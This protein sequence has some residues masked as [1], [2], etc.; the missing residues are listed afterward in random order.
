MGGSE[1]TLHGDFTSASLLLRSWTLFGVI[2]LTSGVIRESLQEEEGTL[3]DAASAQVYTYNTQ[4]ENACSLCTDQPARHALEDGGGG[5]SC[6]CKLYKYVSDQ[7]VK[8]F[9]NIDQCSGITQVPNFTLACTKDILE[10]SL[11]NN[12][13][14][15]IGSQAFRGLSFVENERYLTELRLANTSLRVL[16]PLAF[17]GITG[18]VHVLDLSHNRLGTLPDAVY[19]LPALQKLLLNSNGLTL[20]G[21]QDTINRGNKGNASTHL[22]NIRILDLS[23]NHL[24]G[25]PDLLPRTADSSQLQELRLHGNP[26]SLDM[27][28]FVPL[29]ARHRKLQKVTW[30]QKTLTC[31]CFTMVVLARSIESDFNFP[32]IYPLGDTRD[33]DA[34][35]GVFTEWDAVTCD[36]QSAPAFVGRP[37]GLLSDA[38][39]RRV[40]WEWVKEHFLAVEGGGGELGSET[41]GAAPPSTATLDCVGYSVID[42]QNGSGQGERSS[43]RLL[44]VM[45]LLFILA[46]MRW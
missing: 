26:I 41:M 20:E 3:E 10:L 32:V 45:Q 42:S 29:L 1:G 27:S 4:E 40:C 37:V 16:D 6:R 19:S 18:D 9:Y 35:A 12:P 43:T 2:L 23:N 13:Y 39:V 21:L 46:V 22:E 34:D 7:Q 28:A 14:G 15:A 17:D 30:P 31:S 11:S 36:D 33:D 44:A 8:Q 25:V 38:E 5:G 24:Q